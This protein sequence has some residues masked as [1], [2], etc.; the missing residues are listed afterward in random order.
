MDRTGR[1]L[2]S[3]NLNEG[4]WLFAVQ[5]SIMD[6]KPVQTQVQHDKTT[7]EL[8][9]CVVTQPTANG[10]LPHHTAQATPPLSDR[11]EDCDISS[12]GS[13]TDSLSSND[14]TGLLSRPSPC[15]HTKDTGREDQTRANHRQP[16][17]TSPTPFKTDSAH[18]QQAAGGDCCA[19]CLLACLFCELSS[20]CSALAQCL[21]CG[22]GVACAEMG[23]A[24][25]CSDALIDCCCLEEGCTEECGIVETCCVSTDCLEI[26]LECCSICF[27][28]WTRPN[29][30]GPNQ[31]W[32]K[33]KPSP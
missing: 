2:W 1:K 10:I 15:S 12:G 27:P 11:S 22:G 33:T 24:C 17:S 6:E 19:H 23:G 18:I 25:C 31:I 5:L 7:S 14:D 28:S 26:C 20:F 16:S 4:P 29:Q 30:P 8:S 21:L 32:T 9:E 13:V 3:T